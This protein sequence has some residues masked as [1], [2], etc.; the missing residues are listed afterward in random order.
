VLYPGGDAC[1]PEAFV[2]R[3]PRHLIVLDGT[4]RSADDVALK[5]L[6]HGLPRIGMPER[7]ATASAAARAALP[8]DGRGDRRTL[9]RLE[10]DRTVPAILGLRAAGR[11]QLVYRA[12]EPTVGREKRA[13]QRR[14]S[15]ARRT[16]RARRDDIVVSRQ[17][18]ASWRAAY[19]AS[20]CSSSRASVDG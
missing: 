18:N 1:D 4:W 7:R 12:P 10:G 13:R 6:A 17:T 5:S 14:V 8:R 11:H 16:L 15:V 9:G 2:A 19:G 20:W 3:P